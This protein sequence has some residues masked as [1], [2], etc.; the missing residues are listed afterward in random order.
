MIM[1]HSAHSR[2][3]ARC[4]VTALTLALFISGCEP[5]SKRSPPSELPG[6]ASPPAAEAAATSP[7][8]EA[9]QRSEGTR[10]AFDQ[11]CAEYLRCIDK[12]CAV[13]PAIT[14][15]HDASTTPVAVFRTAREEQGAEELARFKLELA[16]SDAEQRRG[17]M[18]RRSMLPDWGMIFIYPG[19]KPRSFWMKNT[20]LSLD[21]IFVD[22]GG[23]VVRVIEHVEPLTLTSRP[24]ERPARYVVELNAGEASEHG[25]KEGSYMAL[26]NPVNPA[27]VPMP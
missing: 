22:S 14:G 12:V 6:A 24:S 9:I 17:L 23:E 19:D 10:C 7:S 5:R 16:L 15:I 11:G 18:Y 25:I 2:R 8:S 3:A 13:P 27:H 21:M 26:E 1:I 20:Y 4:L